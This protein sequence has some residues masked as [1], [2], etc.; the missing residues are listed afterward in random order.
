MSR[1]LASSN[2][3][4]LR[5][6]QREATPEKFLPYARH[7]NDEMVALDSGDIM[8][9]FEL[10]GRAFETADVRDL[11]D[12]HTKLNGMLRN[13]H[14]ERL[15]IWT[16]LIRMRVDQYPGG[17]FKSGFA[18]DLDR[19]YFGRI[20]R[21][22]MFIN[23]F[24][25]TLVI[26]PAATGGDK[27][28]QLF[29]RKVSG[30]PKQGP[31]LDESLIELL[32][33]KA[34]DFEKLMARCEPRR[35]SIYEY[36]GLMFSE[37]MEVA[38]MVMT[39]RHRRVPVVRGHLGGALYRSRT[40]FGAETIEVRDA[41]ASAFGGIFGI[42]EYPA[43]TTPRQFEALLSVD[44]GFVLTQS[45]T[46]LG[47]AAAS[48]KFRLRMTQM[49]NSGDRAVSQADALIDAG[50]DL[51]SNRFVLG[52]HHFTLAVY[53]DSMKGLRDH[54]SVARAALADT[55]MVAAREGAALEAA[56][57]S[58]LVGNFAWRARPAPITSL[59]FAAFSPFHTFPAGSASGNH[60]G[61]AIALLKTNARSPYFFN[62]HKG[63]L[64]HTLIIGPSGGGKTVLLNFLMAQAEKTGARQIFI[65]KDRGAQ[66]FV[67]ASGG[68]Y[69]ALHNGVAT[70]FSPLKAL[71]DAPED[72][73]FLSIFIRQ[74]VRA[75]GKPISVQEER[76][77]ED[78]ISA[79]M[80]LPAA[81]R[82]LSALRSM[83]GMKDS[84]GVGA[85]LEKWTAEG[86]LGWVFD[87]PADSMTLDARFIGFD[88]TDFLDNA[89]I[90]TP[91]MLY[92]FHR[93][94]QLLTGERMIICIDEFWKALGDEA[95]RRFAQDGLKT[96]RK[97]NAV[98]VFATQS[99]ADA[100][101]SNISHSILEQ[102]ATKIML[103][104]PFGARR[105]YVDG[106]ALSEAEF[107]LVRE[108]LAPESHKFLVKQGHDSVV[109]ELDL[110]GLD[111]ALAVLSGRAETTAVADEIIAEVGHDP[112]VWLPL[113]HKRRRPS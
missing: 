35:C 62:F 13:L 71:A 113:F 86:S 92:L 72:K 79:V 5:V 90:R 24:F 110:A 89:D 52:D 85:R 17:A 84:S 19:A 75:D 37:T 97:R 20:N 58:Q 27:I 61:D 30:Q 22:R 49:E 16:H 101:K 46:F 73:T 64:G 1:L 39:G 82:S 98:L 94:D 31:M 95:F 9:T 33:D 88:M 38:D 105:D 2:A 77:I 104:N 56:Y 53:A 83:L 109:V 91:V 28:I 26:R 106:F 54:M 100:L 70:G 112:A 80:K 107:K 29:K 102:V 3:V 14:D 103:P 68:T 36:R 93:I 18:S 81:D 76:L 21:E 40:I 15:S 108:E 43:Q 69:L 50:D 57:W 23:R 8:L 4:P 111:D 25:A 32:D 78:G 41:D 6:A 12:W 96:Y 10:Q 47:R 60:W 11:N 87:N 65:D 7:V 48:E 59:N 67:Q 34:R 44:F 63:D 45:F 51:M 99:P 74:L 66:I 55:G 42:R